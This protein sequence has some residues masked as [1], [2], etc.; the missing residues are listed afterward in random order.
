MS[1]VEL[2][3]GISS[4]IEVAST[5]VNSLDK[6]DFLQLLVTQLQYQDPLNPMESTEFTAQL[7][8]FSS[9]EQLYNVNSNL[10]ELEGI[11]NSLSS[12]EAVDFIGKTVTASGD[13]VYVDDASDEWS[14]GVD[15]ADAAAGVYAY[16]YDKSGGLVQTLET[17]QMDAGQ[18]SLNW[19]GCDSQGDRVADGSYRFEVYAV[20]ANGNSLDV[21]TFVGG[22]ITGVTYEDDVTYLKIGE[23]KIDPDTVLEVSEP[24][25]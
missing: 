5:E 10:D 4:A 6:D 9:L 15:L 16:I 12:Y 25:E 13:T 14:M 21:G 2:D 3:T 18:Q 17:G 19:D 7:A 23:Q 22:T 24:D 1:L 8:Q 11:Q 20:D